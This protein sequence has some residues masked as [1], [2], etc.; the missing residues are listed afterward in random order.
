MTATVDHEVKLFKHRDTQ[1]NVL[2]E[3][4]RGCLRFSPA[5]FYR[6]GL[7]D[8]DFLNSPI[9]ILRIGTPHAKKL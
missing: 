1:K 9:G 8:I 2:S 3:Y 7:S 4:H 6:K 5:N